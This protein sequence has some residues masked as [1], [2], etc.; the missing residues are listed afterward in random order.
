[1]IEKITVLSAIFTKSSCPLT[2]GL[3]PAFVAP[4]LCETLPLAHT[5]PASDPEGR[6]PSALL[7]AGLV[8]WPPL[9][10]SKQSAG[11]VGFSGFGASSQK[12]P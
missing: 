9:R 3:W 12:F 6:P 10:T 5:L 2:W 4:V 1:M 8:N 7:C 11:L